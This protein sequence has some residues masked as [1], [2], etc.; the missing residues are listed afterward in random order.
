MG[1]NDEKM[2]KSYKLLV[3]EIATRMIDLNIDFSIEISRRYVDLTGADLTREQLH[4]SENNMPRVL[5]LK[6]E[7]PDFPPHRRSTELS[8]SL[9]NIYNHI[10]SPILIHMES[11]NNF[12]AR[13]IMNGKEM[14]RYGRLWEQFRHQVDD[15]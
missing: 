7:I 4:N 8:G 10:I 11:G 13:I 14:G 3:S 2:N 6:I 15:Q 12:Q 1:K 5:L 9:V